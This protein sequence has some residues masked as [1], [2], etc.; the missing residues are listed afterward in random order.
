MSHIFVGPY[1]LPSRLDSPKCLDFYQAILPEMLNDVFAHLWCSSWFQL[2]GALSHYAR[3]VGDHLVPSFG[4]GIQIHWL[5]IIH[6]HHQ[7]LVQTRHTL[8]DYPVAA[9]R[10]PHPDPL[11]FQLLIIFSRG[12]SMKSIVYDTPIISKMNL[13]ARN[14]ITAATISQTAGIFENILQSI[15]HMYH[16]YASLPVSAILNRCDIFKSYI[17][18][19]YC[20]FKVFNPFSVLS[21]YSVFKSLYHVSV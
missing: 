18:L 1:I 8:G 12:E 14:S 10:S 20:L 3:I 13:V 7:S 4:K 6:C 17:E 19:F 16:A 15:S 21:L 9:I 11:S 5:Q 2:N